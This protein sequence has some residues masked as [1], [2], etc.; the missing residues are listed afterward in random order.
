MSWHMFLCLLA[1]IG[2]LSSS[3]DS[4][5]FLVQLL[6]ESHMLFRLGRLVLL[7]LRYMPLHFFLVFE[8]LF[9]MIT[10]ERPF[11]FHISDGH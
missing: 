5:L 9:T 1:T 2:K 10:S 7:V 6:Q 4:M 8:L 3:A 11:L